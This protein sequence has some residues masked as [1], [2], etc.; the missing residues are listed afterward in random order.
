MRYWI[1]KS[2]FAVLDV[3]R[4]YGLATL[5]AYS[6]DDGRSSPVIIDCD[7]YYCIDFPYGKP[8]RNRLVNKAEW[9]S[10]FEPSDAGEEGPQWN[11]LF[12]SNRPTDRETK[13]IHVREV[14]EE[15]YDEILHNATHYGLMI[16]DAHPSET[17][18][19]TLDPV[20][21]KGLRGRTTGEYR[22]DQMQIDEIN[23]AL[24]CL[25]GALV[26]RFIYQRNAGYFVVY[27]CPEWVPYGDF[28]QIRRETSGR[29]YSYPSAL[30]AAAHQALLLASKI[31]DRAASGLKSNPRF[32]SI[33][34][35]AV[36]KTGNQWKPNQ[37]GRM[38]ISRLLDF[39]LS[40][41]HEAEAV[42]RTWDYVFRRGSVRGKEDFALALSEFIA[43][44]TL[45]H[46]EKHVR[47]FARELADK[48]KGE[49]MYSEVAM[50]EVTSIVEAG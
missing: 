6:D 15:R 19:G 12:L 22:E 36:Y 50:R 47:L 11:V 10:L 13:R 49:V 16:S 48:V 4:A 45:E 46:F 44:P 9:F 18:T 39:A 3:A 41:T 33:L 27:P 30:A 28:W 26:G 7:A 38:E 25:G 40:K 31:R 17:L 34:Y 43:A 20:G 21:F 2:G 37:A 29:R 32:G 5:L 35:F 23:W 24:G 42:F 8:S 14:L 1:T